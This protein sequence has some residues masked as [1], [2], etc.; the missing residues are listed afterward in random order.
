MDIMFCDKKKIP[1]NSQGKQRRSNDE[2]WN[3]LS[4]DLGKFTQPLPSWSGCDVAR[5]TKNQLIDTYY[6][7]YTKVVILI[8]FPS[9]I[10]GE[11]MTLI[12]NSNSCLTNN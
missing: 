8:S 6:S 2:E 1:R 4:I 3:G 7:T 12:T 11:K 10:L 9:F 5:L